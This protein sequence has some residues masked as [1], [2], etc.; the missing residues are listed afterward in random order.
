MQEV[1]KFSVAVASGEKTSAAIQLS[2]FDAAL[3]QI[4]A[5]F[6]GT[7]SDLEFIGCTNRTG[8]FVAVGDS[9]GAQ[10]TAT[11]THGTWQAFNSVLFG[12]DYVKIITNTAQVAAR[13]IWI[14]G[15][16]PSPR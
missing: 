13:V 16:G 6:E 14:S 5:A 7:T 4:P 1:R 10:A 2:Q 9:S 11:P 12:M 15:H 3:Y 8:S